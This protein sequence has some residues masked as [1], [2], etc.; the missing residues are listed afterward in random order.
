MSDLNPTAF[1][2]YFGDAEHVFELTPPLVVELEHKMGVGIGVIASR[3]S[4]MLFH[5][6]DLIETIRLGLIGGRMAPSEAQRMVD[7]YAHGRPISEIYPLATGTLQKL[8][9]GDRQPEQ[10]ADNADE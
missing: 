9:F 3:V 8:M 7:T 1:K 4:A 10:D 2:G 6:A 5:Q